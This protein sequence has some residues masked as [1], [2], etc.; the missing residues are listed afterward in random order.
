MTT[1]L[2]LSLFI[3]LGAEP[4]VKRFPILEGMIRII[5]SA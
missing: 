2:V 3:K 5:N 1:F 4:Y